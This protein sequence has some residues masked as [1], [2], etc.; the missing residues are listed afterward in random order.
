MWT[1]FA[2][3]TLY[4]T[5]SKNITR[6]NID[7]ACIQETH[8]GSVD[9]LFEMVTVFTSSGYKLIILSK[10][11]ISIRGRVAVSIKKGFIPN[12]YEITKYNKRITELRIRTGKGINYLAILNKYAPQAQSGGNGGTKY[13]SDIGDTIHNI[14]NNLITL[15]RAYSNGHISKSTNKSH[16]NG[17]WEF[18]KEG[19]IQ[20]GSNL[21]SLRH[22]DD[23]VCTTTS[24]S[25]KL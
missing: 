9:I 18:R 4:I 3:M 5:Q 14:P 20:D 10:S 8:N 11:A 17:D 1:L 7:I 25:G 13:R 22:G 6:N 24:P 23:L 16:T 15:W 19:E 12:V 21:L 2:L